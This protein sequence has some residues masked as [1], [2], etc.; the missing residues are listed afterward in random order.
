MTHDVVVV[1]S[2]AS[3]VSAAVPLAEAGLRVAML[4]YGQGDRRYEDA[5][6]SAPFSE[7]RRSDDEQHEYFLG[8]D[9]EGIPLGSTGVGAQLTPPRQFIT[10]DTDRLLPVESE[11]FSPTQSLAT[12]GLASGWGA[13]CF[14]FT[15]DDFEDVA[16]VEEDLVPHY[17]RVARRIGVAGRRDDVT[18]FFGDA[19]ITL[20]PAEI[21]TNAT[22][23]LRRYRD[24]RG[25]LN[26]RGFFMGLPRLALATRRHRG[27]GPHPY[28]EMEYWTD[29]RKSV[30]RP[31]WTLEELR[32]RPNF[33]YVPGRL[34][35]R[36]S[37]DGDGTVEVTSRLADTGEAETLRARAL[38]LAAGALSTVRIVLRSLDRYGEEVPIVSNPYTY[39]PVVNLAM[40]GREPRERRHGLAQLTAV[41]RPSDARP[42]IVQAQFYSYRSLLAF[43]L[44]RE[45]PLPFPEALGVLRRLMPLLGVVAINHPDRPTPRKRAELRRS[46][47]GDPDRLAV[48]YELSPEEDRLHRARERRMAA[49]FLRLGC[50]PI[51]RV[52]PGHGSSIHYGGTLPM[53]GG[54]RFLTT[55]ASG[56]LAETRSVHVVDGSV[57][58]HLPAKALTFTMMANAD[59]VGTELARSL[60]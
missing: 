27:R 14:P 17:R 26:G 56:R 19:G 50:V 23:L 46:A 48:R 33:R 47:G 8:R 37:E 36:F 15:G 1:G 4:D 41:Y 29:E 5:V 7:V 20:P 42:G 9:F 44:L 11:T 53:T 21:D 59:R 51:R 58:R 2:G 12:G 45:V 25:S 35:R 43:R 60:S 39:L 38:V 24:R 16:L 30:W 6:P 40:L 13:G 34:V 32:E 57:F 49:F 54:D 28:H 31:R 55:D 3:G 10:E 22:T 52:R 18:P